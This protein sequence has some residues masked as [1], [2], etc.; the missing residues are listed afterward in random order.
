MTG[1]DRVRRA[2]RAVSGTDVDLTT[3]VGSITLP[4]PIMTASGTAGHADE[5]GTYFPLQELG[6]VVVK[7]LSVDPWP[8]NP[9]PRVHQTPSGMLNSVG[10]QGPGLAA[11][12][13]DDLPSLMASGARVVVSI[14]G[15]RVDDYARAAKQLNEAMATAAGTGAAAAEGR[16]VAG[17]GGVESAAERRAVAGEAGQRTPI[18]ALEVNVSC[19]NLED[20]RKMFAHSPTATAE[21]LSAVSEECELPL[22]AKLSP[23]VADLA[24]IAGAALASGAE[25]VTLVNTVLGMAIDVEQRRPVLGAG[26]G[27]LS[28]AAIHPVAVRAVYDCRA[29]FPEAAIVGVGGVMSGVDAVELLMAGADAV[30]V[31]TATFRDPRAPRRVLDELTAWCGRH[32]VRSVAEL[33]GVAHE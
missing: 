1:L 24:E 29:A 6:A 3:R 9:A 17:P 4:N 10:L 21:V 15:Q 16:A 28:G 11:W 30:Q 26:G 25:A 22:W 14:W 13:R 7:S 5:L 32:G 12:L 31:G 33:R 2:W 8:G 20:R 23:N 27:G 18:I 19:P